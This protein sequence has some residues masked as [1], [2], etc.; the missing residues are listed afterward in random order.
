MRARVTVRPPTR[1]PGC[2]VEYPT[3]IVE[4]QDLNPASYE[5]ITTR[6]FA[7]EDGEHP[8]DVI[9][10]LPHVPRRNCAV[11]SSETAPSAP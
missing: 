6:D 1:S 8:L 7:R 5:E 3:R 4:T 11:G 10:E 9:A 2:G